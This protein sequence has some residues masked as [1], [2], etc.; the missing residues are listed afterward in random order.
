MYQLRNLIS[1]NNVSKKPKSNFNACDDFLETVIT[2][3]I[4]QAALHVLGMSN[5]DGTPDEKVISLPYILWT[6]PGWYCLFQYLGVSY[7]NIVI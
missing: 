3:H 7:N 4:L 5:I 6:R 1:N 2:A